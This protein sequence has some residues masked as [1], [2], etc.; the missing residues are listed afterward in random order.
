MNSVLKN[1]WTAEKKDSPGYDTQRKQKVLLG[2]VGMG[3]PGPESRVGTRRVR[4]GQVKEGHLCHREDHR[5][6]GAE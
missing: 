3:M 1:K 5:I 6:E 4:Q 2:K